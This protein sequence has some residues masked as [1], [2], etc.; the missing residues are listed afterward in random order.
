MCTLTHRLESGPPGEAKWPGFNFGGSIANTGNKIT[1]VSIHL[2]KTSPTLSEQVKARVQRRKQKLRL[3]KHKAAQA[4]YREKNAEA[5]REKTRLKMREHRARLKTASEEQKI[6]AKE[7][8]REVDADYRERLRQ[9]W[10]LIWKYV[11]EYGQESFDELYRPLIRLHG[12]QA[13]K[14]WGEL[15][16][17][18][19]RR[20]LTRKK[21]VVVISHLAMK[22]S[23]PLTISQLASPPAA[24]RVC[25]IPLKLGSN[26]DDHE[27]FSRKKNKQYWV[28]FDTGM[29]GVYSKKGQNV[30]DVVGCF[31]TWAEVIDAWAKHCYRRHTKCPTHRDSCSEGQ[32][33]AH[34]HNPDTAPIKTEQAGVIKIRRAMPRPLRAVKQE[35]KQEPDT[36]PLRVGSGSSR[37]R[38]SR[39]TVA[40]AGAPARCRRLARA[41]PPSYT[42]DSDEAAMPAGSAPLFDPNSSEEEERGAGS[43]LA[44]EA[45]LVGRGGAAQPE[46]FSSASRSKVRHVEELQTTPASTATSPAV[47]SVSSLS[48]TTGGTAS[49]A[50]PAARRD[51]GKGRAELGVPTLSG[52]STAWEEVPSEPKG[53]LKTDPFFV[54]ASGT[55][56]HSSA[57]PFV[58]VGAGP[59]QVVIGWD[60]ATK[61]AVRKRREMAAPAENAQAGGSKGGHERMDVDV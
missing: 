43:S 57:R 58:E 48:T 7:R 33:P 51:K 3:L 11:E 2:P 61:Y 22:T 20:Q 45:S 28:L 12:N 23:I 13:G 19:K 29:Q 59:V 25:P 5:L 38:S 6:Q 9:K 18:D 16:A 30:A 14:V 44:V 52:V 49:S 41:P 39:R 42:T 34:P 4:R 15:L 60:A 26:F 17:E 47:S 10:V 46:L 56:H 50:V 27:E 53:V 32:C 36:I 40:V 35:V 8:R 31:Q 55:I 1:L 24:F 37:S 54:S 21:R